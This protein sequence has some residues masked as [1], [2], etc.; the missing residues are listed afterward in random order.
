MVLKPPKVEVENDSSRIIS[1]SHNPFR[2]DKGHNPIN[3][4]ENAGLYFGH[5]I[6]PPDRTTRYGGK[7]RRDDVEC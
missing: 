5:T 1:W 2:L 7:T 3:I 4:L 6:E